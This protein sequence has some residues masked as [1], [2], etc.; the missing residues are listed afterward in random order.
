MRLDRYMAKYWPEYSRSVWQKY[1]ESGLVKVNGEICTSVRQNLS[2]DDIVT[3][4]TLPVVDFQGK[5]L[6]V[7][8]EDDHVTVINKPSGV[9]THAKGAITSEFSVADFMRSRMAEPDDTNRPGIVHRLDRATSG[10]II[11]ARDSATKSQ[12]QKQFQD[13]KAH[14]TYL[15]VVDGLPK[16]LEAKIDLPIERNPKSPST[17]RVGARGKNALTAYKVIAHN[18][19]YSVL[20]LKPYTGRTHQLRVHLAHI[21]VPIVG[22]DIYGGSSSPIRRFCLHAKSLE[23]TIPLSKRKTF[24]AL[25]PDEMTDFIREV[26]YEV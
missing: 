12:L 3:Y 20:E 4:M 18:D 8:Y 13:R 2:E 24:E 6:P 17:F 15:A 25:P 1:I 10:I 21:G 14:K 23:I 9:L 16:H 19:K 22:D 26:G 5:T 7:V 11:C